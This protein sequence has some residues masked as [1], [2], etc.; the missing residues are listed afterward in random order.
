MD[1]TI[2]STVDSLCAACYSATENQ[3]RTTSEC[4]LIS[5]FPTFCDT[6]ILEKRHEG[7]QIHSETMQILRVFSPANSPFEAIF[8]ATMLLHQSFLVYTHM[9]AVSQLRRIVTAHYASL[10]LN[11][12]RDLKNFLIGFLLH[13]NLNDILMTQTTKNM[14]GSPLAILYM[15]NNIVAAEA[16]TQGGAVKTASFILIQLAQLLGFVF[17]AAWFDA[18]EFSEPVSRNFAPILSLE[19]PNNQPTHGQIITIHVLTAMINEIGR[20]SLVS[21][22]RPSKLR[23]ASIRFRDT[24]LQYCLDYAIRMLNTYSV[25]SLDMASGDDFSVAYAHSAADLL[26][27]VFQFDFLGSLPD[28]LSEEGDSIQVPSSWRSSIEPNLLKNLVTCLRNCTSP[29]KTQPPNPQFQELSV[30]IVECLSL[31]I[32]V[33]QSLFNDRDKSVWLES[34]LNETAATLATSTTLTGI[35]S[36]C[37]ESLNLFTAKAKLLARLKMSYSHRELVASPN[38]EAWLLQIAQFTHYGFEK[39]KACPWIQN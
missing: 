11:E 36:N 5:V 6:A 2:I 39:W 12:K 3:V 14:S 7:S 15:G 38:F 16:K 27:A 33:R 20:P 9:F 23:T 37:E 10:A 28:E 22:I 32:S 18:D 31:V 30:L 35:A 25:L 29:R 26:R 8:H 13:Q 17:L 1:A 4:I 21:N 24:Q 19:A 34:I